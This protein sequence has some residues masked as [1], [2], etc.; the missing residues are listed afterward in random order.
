MIKRV[1]F[2]VN[3]KVGILFWGLLAS[4]SVQANNTTQF[5]WS[6]PTGT[7]TM[8]IPT[9]PVMDNTVDPTSM[10]RTTS[11]WPYV[12]KKSFAINLN[13]CI[14]LADSSTVRA[15][16][17]VRG[18][19]MADPAGEGRV[20]MFKNEGTAGGTSTGFAFVVLKSA[21]D[22]GSKS[23]DKASSGEQLYVPKLGGGWYK[24]GENLTGNYSIPLTAA[25]TCGR[26]EWC[27]GTGLK[28]GTLNASIIFTFSYK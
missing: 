22:G 4:G 10:I 25:V 14:G 26:I 12:S 27:S 18:S 28:A 7:C 15:G 19:T 24:P 11:G 6:V 13:N 5:T 9:K 8:D 1:F 2:T 17:T 3:D 20:D 23:D 21:R 16:V